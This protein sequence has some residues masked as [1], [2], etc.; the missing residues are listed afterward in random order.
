MANEIANPFGASTAMAN[1]E[2][3]AKRA[4][5]SANKTPSAGAPDGS[6]YMNFSGKLGKYTIGKDKRAID[7]DEYWLLNVGSF[8]DGYICWKGGKPA[9][10]RMSNIYTG[11]P[12]PAPMSDEL[13]PFDTNRGEGWSQAKG[14]VAKSLDEDVQGYFKNNSVSGVA[15]MA[16][17]ISEV[18]ARLSVGK[19]CWPVFAYD[20]EGFEAQGF[21]N[22]KPKFD[23]KG[24]LDDEALGALSGDDDFD[25]EE[26]MAESAARD[27]GSELDKLP[28]PT[29]PKKGGRKQ[30][31]AQAK[32]AEQAAEQ[33][34]A[35]A[36]AE[37]VPEGEEE[38]APSRRRR[39]TTR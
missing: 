27:E 24:W 5:E 39:R 32:A 3:M 6:D 31:D 35:E 11:E 10:T 19:A 34:A 29:S 38:A 30:A 4:A 7:N 18:S 22:F 33:A 13:G 8:E 21:K 12:I 36:E 16:E 20:S 26:L 15:E 2:E 37:E 28:A 9:S 23:V 1:R 25:V 17:M 14:W